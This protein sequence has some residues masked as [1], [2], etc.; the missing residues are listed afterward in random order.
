MQ[1]VTFYEDDILSF[2]LRS[3][4]HSLV[5]ANDS[6]FTPNFSGIVIIKLT[7]WHKFG[8]ISG[9]IFSVFGSDR[10]IISQKV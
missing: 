1:L 6:T 3:L 8:Y 10:K 7:I 2:F 4:K 9:R 5:R